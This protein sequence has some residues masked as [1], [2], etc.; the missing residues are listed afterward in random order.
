MSAQ[1]CIGTAQFG[2]AY[3]ITNTVGRVPE[4]EVR[5][6]LTEASSA[7][8][9]FLDTAQAYGDSE[10]VIGRN[11]PIPNH[12]RVISKISSQ[13]KQH[14]DVEDVLIWE[15]SIN[16]TLIALGLK[17][18]DSLL[19]HNSADL[20]KPG[21]N[22][23]QEWLLSLRQRGL[24]KRLGVSIYESKDLEGIP[25]DF[26]DLVQLPL[27]LYDQRLLLDGTIS[28][29]KSQG[30]S[31]QVR[32]VFLQGLLLNPVAHW[33]S[34]IDNK[35]HQH[36]LKLENFARSRGSSLLECA[37][38]FLMDQ[39]DIESAVIGICSVRELQELLYSY[40]KKSPWAQDEW[41]IWSLQ[42]QNIIDPRLWP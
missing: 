5:R 29:L 42:N 41:K 32:S 11:L 37:L 1:I 4:I 10:S 31:V 36:H 15:N 21:A 24:V 9:Y 25:R 38:G 26:R 7:G 33:P 2:M 35:S 39:K 30:C 19:L 14:F 16:S 8:I 27:S 28:S 12:F 40:G 34:W 13:T 23:L 17:E 20:R 3:G 18:L 22:L 6:I